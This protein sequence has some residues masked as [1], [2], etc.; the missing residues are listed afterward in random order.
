MLET[1][2]EASDQALW[3]ADQV[4]KTFHTISGSVVIVRYVR[5]PHQND[6]ACSVVKLLLFLLALR[7]R[8]S[9]SYSPDTKSDRISLSEAEIEGLVEE[10]SPE[11]LVEE[12]SESRSLDEKLPVLHRDAFSGRKTKLRDGRKVTKLANY[13]H[14]NLSGDQRLIQ[15]AVET[16]RTHGVGPGSAPGF[17]GTFDVHL[18]L[19]QDI[20]SHF[21]T[22]DPIVYSQSFSTISSICL[23]FANGA[24]SSSQ[25]V[26]SISLFVKEFMPPGA[27]SGGSITTMWTTWSVCSL[28]WPKN[29]DRSLR[30]LFS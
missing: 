26:R 1:S 12:N 17:Y 15:S 18:K 5:S 28:S 4:F 8:F 6:V 13:N 14:H 7:Y 3:L 16:I 19:E 23:H 9:K 20:A 10:W 30:G 21:G 22:E 27:L 25:I 29:V 24:I 11:V 2:D